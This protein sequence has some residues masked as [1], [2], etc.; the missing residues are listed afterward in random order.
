MKILLATDGFECS[1]GAAAFLSRFPL[2]ADDEIV[3]F[4]AV[5][6]LPLTN[7]EVYFAML[8]S[9]RQDIAPQILDLTVGSL[10]GTAARITQH[11]AEGHPAES[12]AHAAEGMNVDLIVMGARG[13]RGRKSAAVGSVTRSVAIGSTRPVLVVKPQQWTAKLAIL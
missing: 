10:G 2:T 7:K 9:I 11:Q 12:V 5:E 1:L 13:A 4:H 6:E 8:R 3:V